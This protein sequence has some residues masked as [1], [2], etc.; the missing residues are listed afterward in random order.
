MGKAASAGPKDGYEPVSVVDAAEEVQQFMS[1]SKGAAKPA[2]SAVPEEMRAWEGRMWH[3]FGRCDSTGFGACFLSYMLPC[4]AFGCVFESERLPDPASRRSLLGS[5]L[6]A[7]C[8]YS[9]ASRRCAA[10][11]GFTGPW[12]SCAGVTPRTYAARDRS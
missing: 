5:Y 11:F 4:V 1:S 10:P 8:L 9:A 2:K 12:G 6:R 3:C 7:R